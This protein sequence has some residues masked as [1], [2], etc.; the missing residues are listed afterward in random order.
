MFEQRL[1][2]GVAVSVPEIKMVDGV[3]AFRV[4]P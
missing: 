3:D 1:N 4:V 2:H